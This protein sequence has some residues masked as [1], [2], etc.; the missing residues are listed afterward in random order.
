MSTS[1]IVFLFDVDNTLLDNDRFQ[2]ELGEYLRNSHGDRTYD[3]YWALFEEIRSELGYADYLGAIERCR[4]EHPHQPRILQA[5]SWLLGYPFA[6]CLYPNAL[7]AVRHMRQWGPVVILSD[8]DAIFQPHK[9][10]RSGLWRAFDGQVL[11]YIHK[12]KE[13]QDVERWH[14]AKRY[15]LID[16]K[17]RVLDA[18]KNIW[19]ERV[20]TIFPRQGRYALDAAALAALRPADIAIDN[21]GDL[22]QYDLEALRRGRE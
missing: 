22:T 13:L 1:D 3:R 15:V 12:E 19:G 18:V 4:L 20:T 9:I 8:G 14:P 5:A 7:A 16:D 10:E 11:I 6:D 2:H 17:L 21:V